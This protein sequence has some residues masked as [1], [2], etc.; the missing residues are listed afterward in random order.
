MS[1]A[2]QV[3][4]QHGADGQPGADD[5]LVPE[6]VAELAGELVEAQDESRRRRLARQI[7][8]LA[9]RSG[10]ATRRG[11]ATSR[12][13]AWQRLQSGT[14]AAAR[15]VRPAKA[16]ALRGAQA[17]GGAAR[18]GAHTGGSVAWRGLRASGQWLSGQVLEMAPKVPIRSLST[19]QLQYPGL[20]TE[21][22][23]DALITGAARAS[24][25]VGAARYTGCRPLARRRSG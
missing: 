16:V 6:R 21:Q 10:R 22:L 12:E 17:T 14:G 2:D 4:N 18:R 11:L 24:A 23:A 25:G 9:G 15:R 5:Q 8:E 7:P 1:P 3:D 13:V 19:L 20:G